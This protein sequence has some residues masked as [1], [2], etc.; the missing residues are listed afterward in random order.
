LQAWTR[1]TADVLQQ[2]ALSDESHITVDALL[3]AAKEVPNPP[4][5]MSIEENLVKMTTNTYDIR[6]ELRAGGF[7]WNSDDKVRGIQFILSSGF[8]V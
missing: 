5:N 6:S 8:R 1:P 7:R 2:L 4:P 3:E